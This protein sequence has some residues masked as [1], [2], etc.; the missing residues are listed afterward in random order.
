MQVVR[1]ADNNGVEVFLLLKQL[2]EVTISRTSTILAGALLS[3]VI[4]VYDFLTRFAACNAA[5]DTERMGQ[6]N[7]IV[8][9]EP[10]PPA[11]NAQQLADRIAEL[12]RI[13]LWMIRADLI[14][15]ANSDILNV[16]LAQKVKHDPEAL[17]TDADESNIDLVARRNIPHTAQHPTRND[18]KTN[19]RCGTLP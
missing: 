4:G 7:G 19:R 3:A 2:A 9:A 8:G 10:I 18:R 6:L 11:I 17:G 13:P 14:G 5:R 12:M 1:G 16:R 15:V